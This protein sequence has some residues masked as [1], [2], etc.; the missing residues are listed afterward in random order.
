MPQLFGRMGFPAPARQP[1]NR[2][3][4]RGDKTNEQLSIDYSR[5]NKLIGNVIAIGS[6]TPSGTIVTS[7][8]FIPIDASRSFSGTTVMSIVYVFV[9]TQTVVSSKGRCLSSFT[10]IFAGIGSVRNSSLTFVCI[11]EVLD[12]TAI[13]K[14][15][16]GMILKL[17]VPTSAGN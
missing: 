8:L 17:S 1:D 15:F 5:T 14:T 16:S 13:R 11:G 3:E 2:G 7:P 9:D 10:S 12:L 4:C 6:G